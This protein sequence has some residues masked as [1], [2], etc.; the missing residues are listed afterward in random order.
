MVKNVLLIQPPIFKSD[1]GVDVIQGAYWN[2]LDK[3]MNDIIIE[4]KLDNGVNGYHA[5]EPNIG[6]LYVAAC[7]NKCGYNLKYVDFSVVDND[8]RDTQKRPINEEDIEKEIGQI[9]KDFLQFVAISCMTVNYKWAVKIAETIK[10]INSECVVVLGGVHGSFEYENILKST[11]S[12]DIVS[13]GEGEE[14]MVEIADMFFGYGMD[15]DKLSSIKSVAFRKGDGSICLTPKREFIQDLDTIP[16]PMYE[17]IPKQITDD[18]MIRVI[19]SRGC[20][21]NC[22]FC[23]PSKIFN[24]LRFRKVKCV[25]DEL[26]YYNKTHGWKLFMIGDLNFLSS[27]DYALDFCNEIIK[28]KLDIVWICQSRVDLVD[29]NITKL[30]KKAGCILIC[31]GIESADQDILDHTNK[32][33]TVDKA[34]NACKMV[35]N[36]GIRLYTY[37]VFGLPNETHDSAHA[38]IKLLRRFLDEDVIDFTHCTMC[39]PFPGTELYKHPEEND[40]TLLTNDYDDYWLGCDYLGAGLPVMETNELSRYEIYAYWQM[41]LAVVAGNLD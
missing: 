27:Y 26:E 36:A 1:L 6:L 12:I 11:K 14:T 41:A 16:Y 18:V 10:N 9:P 39:T 31:L 5:I 3:K 17:L 2:K 32:N 22:S 38:T 33:T 20:S 15:L 8:V 34:L 30:M 19:T 25:V 7:L 35:K 37:W 40:I 23:V 13:I 29:E 4:N 24:K 28:R 21:N